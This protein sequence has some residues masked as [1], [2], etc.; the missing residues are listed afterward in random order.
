MRF[1]CPLPTGSCG[2]AAAVESG[3]RPD[4]GTGRGSVWFPDSAACAS[5]TTTDGALSRR[6]DPRHI[7][8]FPQPLRL[9]WNWSSPFALTCNAVR[10]SWTDSRVGRLIAN[11]SAFAAC[12]VVLEL[13]PLRSTRVTR[14]PRYYGPL[15]HPS[16]PGLSL[17]G[18]PLA[19]TRRHRGGFL[20]CVGFLPQ[21]CH[22]HYPGGTAGSYRSVLP[23]QGQE[24]HSPATAAFP[25][26]VVG[27]L[28]HRC[29]RGLLSIHFRYGLPARGTARQSF[30]SKAPTV[31]FPPPPLQLLPADAT[32]LPGGI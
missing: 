17:A 22:C 31:S 16:R 15:R 20:C 29:F 7:R 30:P 28:P 27:R 4:T 8:Q 9:K 10:S 13:R 32:K 1:S 26:S 25:I 23:R 2:S 24:A 14:F 3:P 18:V 19:V 12:C 21:T 11:P 6:S 5:Y